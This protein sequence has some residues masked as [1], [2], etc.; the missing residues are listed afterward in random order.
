MAPSCSVDARYDAA[1]RARLL[2]VARASIE[3][4]LQHDA[5]LA[6]RASTADAALLLVRA[7]FV[8]LHLAG[9]L[10]GC[11]GTLRARLPLV[12]QVAQSA[13]AAAFRDPRFAPVARD[14]VDQ[15]VLHISV[16]SRPVPLRV[17]S[18]AELLAALRPGV[19]GLVLTEGA[20]SG[21]FLPAVWESIPEPS[22][23]LAHLRHKA[24]LPAGYWSDTLTVERYTAESIP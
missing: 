18:E 17:G 24:G 12:Q 13:F 19:D 1:Q 20:R 11:V 5:P 14:E 2:E 23:F 6:V 8:T 10:R 7:C 16:L 3:H 15:L 21:T 4:G 22:D 9:A